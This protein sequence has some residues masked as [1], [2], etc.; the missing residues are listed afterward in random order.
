MTE[1]GRGPGP[2]PWQPDDPL[3]G[4]RPAYGSGQGYTGTEGDAAQQ[5]GWHPQDGER[6]SSY[7]APG[8]EQQEPYGGWDGAAAGTGQP[9]PAGGD[10]YG[11]GEHPLPGDP[12]GTGQHPLPDDPYG[13]SQHPWPDD[14]YATA[15]HPGPGDGT[16]PVVG[17]S[18]QPGPAA[19]AVPHA[20]EGRGSPGA[21]PDPETGWDPGPDQGEAAFFADD[22]GGSGDPPRDGD[23]GDSRDDAPGPGRRRGR[24]RGGRGRGKGRGRGRNGCAC[25]VALVV[26]AGGLGAVGYVGYDFYQ[27]R[28]GP[29]PDYTGKGYGQVQVEI[30]EGA[31]LS[32][33]GNILK[34][35]GVVKSHDA[36]VEAASGNS[37]ANGIS[38]GVYTLRKRMAAAEALALMTDPSALNT[39]TISEGLRAT[40]IYET[41]DRKLELAKGTTQKVAKEADLGLPSWARGKVEG[42]LFPARYDVSEDTKPADLL[43]QMVKRARNEFRKIDLESEARKVGRTP[44]EVL[45]I[46]SLI[47]AEAQEDEDFG[48]VSRV[49]Y[50]RLDKPMP[51]QFDSTINYAKGRSSL[52]VSIEDTRMESPYNTYRHQGLPPSPID[53]PGHQALEAAL[54]PTKGDWLFFVTVRPGDT[55]F[56]DDLEEHERNVEEF[57]QAQKEKRERGE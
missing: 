35:K 42:F 55:R 54:H 10:P 8:P 43:R 47:Q 1:Y 3:F 53:N 9:F 17:Q 16:A 22:H 28:F 32:D 33:M 37:E 15:G 18:P 24:A 29:A 34:K 26:L 14:P 49:I 46:A 38:A 40:K 12:Y 5:G 39:L 50:N 31:T 19:N 6:Y 41:I 2:E 52:D 36:F 20:A 25:V 13:T 4:D 7:P 57:N 23:D 45:T 48:K 21:G 30:P 51:L 27:D 56:T 11:T 44:Y